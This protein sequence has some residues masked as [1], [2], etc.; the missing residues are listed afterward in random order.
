VNERELDRNAARR[1][2]IIRHARE[3]TGN[4]AMTCRYYGISRQVFYTWYRRYE[5]EGL[6]G[7][8]DRSKRPLHSPHETPSEV[9]G[10]IIYLRTHYHFGPAKISMYL[11]R[12]HDVAVSQSGVWRILKRLDLNRLP[13]SQRYKRHDRKWKRYEKPRPGCAVQVDVKFIAPLADSSRK[14]YYQFTAIDDC[15]RLR[16]LRIYDRLNQKTAIAF[17]D[18]LLDKFPFR[19][20]VIQT[21]NGSEFQTAFHWH[22]ADRGIR[23]IYIKPATPRLNGKVER[24]H[25]IDGEEFYRQLKG[26]VID[27]A[28]LFNERLQQWQDFYNYDRPHGALGGQTPYERLRQKTTHQQAPT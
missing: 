16:V 10:K 14:R 17:A 28:E 22:L 15:T 3:V 2:A 24:S 20:E 25:R 1:L 13:A 6:A 4:V 11:Q 19:V 18:F 5:T 8:R 12:Y 23:H 9:V 21:D 7:L 26:V 27:D